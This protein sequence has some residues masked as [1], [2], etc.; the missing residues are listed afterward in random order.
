MAD[1]N[2]LTAADIVLLRRTGQSLCARSADS[3]KRS[4]RLAW[5]RRGRTGQGLM[6]EHAAYVAV[7]AGANLDAGPV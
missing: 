2:A 4:S 3:S 5:S 1:P 7:V 6:L